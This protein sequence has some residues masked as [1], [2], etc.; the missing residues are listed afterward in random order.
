MSDGV[1][2][3]SVL[4]KQRIGV[5]LCHFF[6]QDKS[7]QIPQPAKAVYIDMIAKVILFQ[8]CDKIVASLNF[9]GYKA[10]INYYV[11][12][13]IGKYYTN[14][15]D[16]NYIWKNQ[17]ISPEMAN[18]IENLALKVWNHFQNPVVQGIN[19]SQWCKKKDCWILL[20]SRFENNE[21]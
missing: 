17:M 1:Y 11:M 3:I 4:R 14:L 20:Q 2:G 13:L 12:A 15:F 10:Q 7:G 8:Q 19:I 5:Q 21:L 16:A 6:G 18:A 9:G